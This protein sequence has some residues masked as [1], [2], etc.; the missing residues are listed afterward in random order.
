MREKARASEI[1]WSALDDAAAALEATT[2]AAARAMSAA[3]DT[4]AA[5][6]ERLNRREG[7]SLA[8]IARHLGISRQAVASLLTQWRKRQ[9][10][11]D[12]GDDART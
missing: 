9:R 1:D 5:E 4:R 8:L 7:A 12:R 3:A 6:I 10:D 11:A 2:A